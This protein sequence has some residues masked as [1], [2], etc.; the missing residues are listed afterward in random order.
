MSF[1]F[2]QI[3]DHHL[4]ESEN[5]LREGFS[6][7]LAFRTV[8]R[9]IAENTAGKADFIVSTGDVVDPPTERAYQAVS[10]M[11]H[12]GADAAVPGPLLISIEGLNNYPLY[13][14][15][16]NHD[17]RGIFGSQFFP[18][19]PQVS[20]ANVTFQHKGVQFVCLDWGAEAKAV[21]YPET[22]AFLKQALQTPL[23]CVILTHHHVL[24]I[25]SRW[26][27]EFIADEA[28]LFWEVIL[29]PQVREKVLGIL[30][31]HVHW[32]SEA[33]VEGIPVLTLRS[34]AFP[35]ALQDEPLLTLK[36]PQYRF[37]TIHNGVLTSRLFEAPM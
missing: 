16:G 11:L 6:P 8:L 31:G 17:D 14:M 13:V 20:L 36:P 28:E 4:T 1:S 7:A 24:P 21:L 37:V 22:L 27:D 5:Q 23:P 33:Y 29:T 32:T 3:T 9:H 25:G 18:A 19:G 15:P 30:T 34:T 12:I 35:I 2:I 10:Q 26:M